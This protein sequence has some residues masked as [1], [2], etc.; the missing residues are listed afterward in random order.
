MKAKAISKKILA[1]ILI[2]AVLVFS[3]PFASLFVS[4]ANEAPR[5]GEAKMDDSVIPSVADCVDLTNRLTFSLAQY[6]QEYTEKKSITTT[7]GYVYFNGAEPKEDGYIVIKTKMTF[8]G[9]VD[10]SYDTDA[11]SYS[12]VYGKAGVVIGTYGSGSKVIVSFRRCAATAYLFDNSNK[13]LGDDDQGFGSC[14]STTISEIEWTVKYDPVAKI[15]CLWANGNYLGKESVAALENFE[16]KLGFAVQGAG[17]TKDP[18]GGAPTANSVTFSDLQVYGQAQIDATVMPLPEDFT[19]YTDDFYFDSGSVQEERE[20]EGTITVV[21][22]QK[23]SGAGLLVPDDGILIMSAK[24]KF[25]GNVDFKWEET[26]SGSGEYAYAKGWGKV[27]FRFGTVTVDGA[28][29]R[30]IYVTFRRCA[31]NAYV[32]DSANLSL[33]SF[34]AC[35]STTAT[36]IEMTFKYD[37]AAKKIHLWVDGLYV[38]VADMSNDMYK[39]LNLDA[40]GIVTQGIGST[41]EDPTDSTNGNKTTNSVVFSDFKIYGKLEKDPTFIMPKLEPMTENYAKYFELLKGGQSASYFNCAFTGE[42]GNNFTFNGLEYTDD[43]VYNASFDLEYTKR[44]KQGDGTDAA[45]GSWRFSIMSAGGFTY[46]LSMMK[47]TIQVLANGSG[48]SNTPTVS[49]ASPIGEK[50]NIAVQ[51]NYS[52]NYISVWYDGKMVIRA[53]ELP[54]TDS[55][56]RVPVFGGK[57]DAAYGKISNLKTWG[58]GLVINVSEEYKALMNDPFYTNTNLPVKPEGNINYWQYIQGSNFQGDLAYEID[59]EDGF[60]NFWNDEAATCRFLDSAGNRNINGLKNMSTFAMSF[61]Y[62]VTDENPEYVEKGTQRGG[63]FTLRAYNI[64]TSQGKQNCFTIG[65]YN[66]AIVLKVLKDD[67]VVTTNSTAWNRELNRVYDITFVSSPTWLKVYVDGELMMATG[68]LAEYTI[69]IR[70]KAVHSCA[71]FYDVQIF[72]LS[73]DDE[74]TTEPVEYIKPDKQLTGNVTLDDVKHTDVPLATSELSIWIAVV[75]LGVVLCL[76]GAAITTVVFIK[77]RKASK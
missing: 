49:I 59:S 51:Y 19:D 10:F 18:N 63:E 48:Y 4:A 60:L 37:V 66:N 54:L 23:L 24:L 21:G 9:N 64:P 43:L 39:K 40:L 3:V 32:F 45:W 11:D 67:S 28:G 68:G 16:F 13:I 52:K 12:K 62:K 69:D 29:E 15:V 26:A 70:Y 34:G 35:S 30:P 17:T 55:T 20:N 73:P 71:E 25:N 74:N 14:G 75:G 72:D 77:K 7:D 31:A 6:Q 27:G 36:E 22:D 56:D 46:Q 58:T 65:L 76:A 50:H 5:I 61:K 38:G 57:F 42:N 2:A 1:Y 47:D 41:A 33:T 53:A 44:D 8:N